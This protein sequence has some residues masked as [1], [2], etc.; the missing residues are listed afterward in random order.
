MPVCIPQLPSTGSPGDV[1][2]RRES[3]SAA[4]CGHMEECAGRHGQ[5]VPSGASCASDK[6]KTLWDMRAVDGEESTSPE[7][8]EQGEGWAFFL[9]N[10]ILLLSAWG[11]RGYLWTDA[12]DKPPTA[13]AQSPDSFSLLLACDLFAFLSFVYLFTALFPVF[14]SCLQRQIL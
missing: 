12:V 14:S 1:P 4:T 5:P 11:T 3:L 10:Q 6:T 7:H 13:E 2:T 8:T 9:L